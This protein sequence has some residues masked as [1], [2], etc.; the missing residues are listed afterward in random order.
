MHRYLAHPVFRFA[1]LAA[2]CLLVLSPSNL[3]LAQTPAATAAPHPPPIPDNLQPL[4]PTT[5]APPPDPGS[6]LLDRVVAVVNTQVILASDVDLEVRLSR[7]LPSSDRDDATPVRALD[8]L[9]TRALIEQQILQEDPKGLDIVPAELNASLTELRQNLPAC[10]QRDCATPAGWAAYL[11]TLQL[12]PERVSEY[13]TSRLAVLRFIEQ[14]F[15]AGIRITPEEIKNYY[16]TTLLPLYA[17]TADAP[18]LDRISPRIQEILLQQKVNA[19]LNDWLKSLQ[20][21]G[22]VEVLDP[23]LRATPTAEAPTP[24]GKAGQ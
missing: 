11:A 15:R 19:L 20:D 4:I 23:T 10:K 5:V 17:R 6:E 1:A 22:Q 3:V 21:Q 13:W 14:R 12:T 2:A 18:P 24:Q 7:I 9:T 8:R 16:D